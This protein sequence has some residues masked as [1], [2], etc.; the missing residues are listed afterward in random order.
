MNAPNNYP[1]QQANFIPLSSS[2]LPNSNI[3]SLLPHYNANSK[4]QT[5]KTTKYIMVVFP[6]H[7]QLT[8]NVHTLLVPSNMGLAIEIV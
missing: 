6:I 2:Q 5:L 4:K 1:L 7:S 3:Y 8:A